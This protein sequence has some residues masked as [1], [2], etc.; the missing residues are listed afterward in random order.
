M[1][2]DEMK[3]AGYRIAGFARLAEASSITLLD[4]IDG[5][6]EALSGLAS[7]MS[8]LDQVLESLAEAIKA[9]PIKTCQYLDPE[10]EAIDALAQAASGFKNHL[11]KLVR[12][13]AEIDRDA[14]LK[15]DHCEALHDAYESATG[16][17]AD[18]IE[19]IEALRALVISRD[20]AAEPR[21]GEAFESAV[22]LIEHLRNK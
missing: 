1:H 14:R 4:A 15:G 6:I 7:V 8:G 3:D 22:A 20:L 12:R 17:M 16:A 2:C 11:T 18:L 5:T 13:R 19:N 10:D 9:K 21:D